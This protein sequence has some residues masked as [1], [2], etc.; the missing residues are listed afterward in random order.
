MLRTSRQQPMRRP[1]MDEG[2]KFFVGL[3]VHKETI[4]IAVA[5][6]GRAAAR[7]L[8]SIA[9]DVPKLPK[10]LARY[11]EPCTVHM[12]YEAGPTGYGLQRLL[13]GAAAAQGLPV[14]P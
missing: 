14:A 3:D 13:T 4:A 9:H 7:L 2:I 5:E 1:A 11:G 12:V 8:G 6:P 10:V